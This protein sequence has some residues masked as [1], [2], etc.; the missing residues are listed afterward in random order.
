MLFLALYF[1]VRLVAPREAFPNSSRHAVAQNVVSATHSFVMV[2]LAYLSCASA[3]MSDTIP[4]VTVLL[5]ITYFAYDAAIIVA[6]ALKDDWFY[7]IHHGMALLMLHYTYVGVYPL[8]MGAQ[9]LL[10]AEASNTFIYA[11]SL[12]RDN[13]KIYPLPYIYT[14]V[15]MLATYVPLRACVLTIKCAHLLAFLWHNQNGVIAVMG[16]MGPLVALLSMSWYYSVKMVSIAA[17]CARN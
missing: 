2:P 3:S 6:Y 14:S 7:V 1:I 4:Q 15:A 12:L 11:W 9:V 13:R 10:W 17:K 5:S 8:V 16:T